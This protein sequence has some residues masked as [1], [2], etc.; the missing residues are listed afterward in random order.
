M[1]DDSPPA[2]GCLWSGVGVET[3]RG[4]LFVV[5]LTLEGHH[6]KLCQSHPAEVTGWPWSIVVIM[7]RCGRGDR[8]YYGGP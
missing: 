3:P 2:G 6:R 4:G 1:Y 5:T 7:R 8:T